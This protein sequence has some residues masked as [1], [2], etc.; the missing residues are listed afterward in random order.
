MSIDP[1]HEQQFVE[2]AKT[3]NKAGIEALYELYFEPI[4]RFCYWQTNRS[5]DAEDLTQDIF[6]EM[7][8]SIHN[9]KGESSFKNWL[10]ILAKRQ[11]SAWI[12]QKYELPTEP[13]FDMIPDKAEWIDQEN[14]AFK[15]KVLENLLK[16]LTDLERLVMKLRYL[17][18]YTV[19][20]AAQKL[21]LSEGNVKVICHRCIKKLQGN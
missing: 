21:H 4:Y 6:I 14:D 9:F 7:A 17:Q 15:K 16:K 19:K 20:E 5:D 10:Y 1:Q 2:L 13:L 3:G 18:N 11:I 12:R 8:K